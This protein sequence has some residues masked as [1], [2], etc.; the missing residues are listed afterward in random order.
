MNQTE[1]MLFRILHV[2]ASFL[3]LQLLW[4]FFSLGIITVIPATVAMYTV[5]LEWSKH[6]VDII[7][8]WKTFFHAFKMNFK[9]TLFLGINVGVIAIILALNASILPTLTGF[10]HLFMQVIWLF[11]VSIFI[12]TFIAILPLTATTHL[13]GLKLWKNAWIA[14]VTILP[15]I[16]LI[17]VIGAVFVVVV[18]YYPMSI[19]T[20][21]SIFAFIHINLWQR[22]VKKLPKDFLDQCLLKYR[23]R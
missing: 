20:V 8:I 3:T 10:L 6:G 13:K 23:Y 5:V 7:G 12:F 18:L 19:I 11:A 15:D 1:A 21:V 22:A 14:S 16:M 4:F 17:G 9:N 2:F